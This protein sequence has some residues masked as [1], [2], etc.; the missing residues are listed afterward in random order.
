MSILKETQSTYVR[1]L[2]E[3]ISSQQEWVKFLDFASQLTI[4]EKQYE[5]GFAT[6]IGIY[7]VNPN[8]TYCLL[9][10][11]WNDKEH[12]R[13]TKRKTKG[14]KVLS[15]SRGKT[16]YVNL[17]DV[18]QTGVKNINDIKP[19]QNYNIDI[20]IDVGVLQAELSRRFNIKADTIENQITGIIK[21]KLDSHGLPSNM[22]EFLEQ[23]MKYQIFKRYGFEYNENEFSWAFLNDKPNVYD[24]ATLGKIMNGILFPMESIIEN[25][26]QNE[27]SNIY[28]N[29]NGKNKVGNDRRETSVLGR[30]GNE[31]LSEVQTE[32]GREVVE[33][34][35]TSGRD[36]VLHNN[37][38]PTRERG[39]YR[40]DGG[41]SKG[42]VSDN[43]GTEKTQ[44]VPS[45]ELDGVESQKDGLRTKL[46]GTGD[47][48]SRAIGGIQDSLR[49]SEE[50]R[51]NTGERIDGNEESKGQV[52]INE[53][54]V[55]DELQTELLSGVSGIRETERAY[56]RSTTEDI[57]IDKQ[58][59]D[60]MVEIGQGISE[61][62]GRERLHETSESEE[63]LTE[64]SRG[65][66]STDDSL[67]LN[68]EMMAVENNN[69]TVISDL[70]EEKIKEDLYVGAIV[71]LDGNLWEVTGMSSMMISFENLDKESMT[72]GHSF[73]GDYKVL[74]YKLIKDYQATKVENEN[75]PHI[76]QSEQKSTI[77]ENLKGNEIYTSAQLSL[78]EDIYSAEDKIDEPQADEI[79]DKQE[80]I[81][82]IIR[83]DHSARW[84]DSEKKVNDIQLSDKFSYKDREYTVVS[85]KGIYP[86]DIGIAYDEE[87]SNG[88][89]YQVTENI[90]KYKLI[91]EG[92]YL[93]KE[94]ENVPHIAQ[95]KRYNFRI[96]DME[97]G[98][99]GAK[100]KY[101]NN[102]NAI[103]LLKSL[104]SEGR[105]A[106]PEEQEILS[107]YVGW[108]GLAQAFDENNSQWSNE[109]KELQ[110]LL[111]IEEYESAR[112][113]TLNAHYTSPTVINAMYK[114]IDN[115][116]F[117]TGNI[118]EPS[119]GIGNFLG[120]L[121]ESMSQS[122]LYGVELDSIT[123]RIAKQL[124]QKADISV[125][126]FE[127]KHYP[128]N[129]F[130][131]AIGNVPFGSYKVS[132]KRYDKN[133]WYI[134]DYFI[135]KSLDKVKPNGIIAFITSKGTMDKK[136][137]TVRKYIA[138]RAEL[139]GAIR[140]PNNAFKANAGTEVTS[141][142]LFFQKRERALDIE[143]E[144]VHLSTTE[145]G[146]PIN[147]YFTENPEMVLGKMVSGM[148]MYGNA[149][150]TSCEP[151]ENANLAEQ[152]EK[153]ILNI[154]PVA[155]I[156]SS[157]RKENK[158]EI[159]E[160]I[161]ADMNVK[162]Y[163]YAIIDEKLYFRENSE[164]ELCENIKE[165]DRIKGMVEIRDSVRTL[166]DY[167]IN[168]FDDLLIKSEQKNL[169]QLY[170]VFV[171]KYGII[172]SPENRKAFE[173]DNSFNLLSSLEE[174]KKDEP[175]RKAPIFYK[176][177]INARK[178]I[179]HVDTSAE[180]LVVSLAEKGCVDLEYMSKLTNLSEEKIKEDLIGVIFPN[181][182]KF[183]NNDKVVYETAD[184]YLSGNIREKLSLAKEIAEINPIY[185][186]NVI[187]LEQAMPKPLNAT[188]IDVRLGST[189]IEPKFVEQFIYE[190]LDT[191]YYYKNITGT[192]KNS[193]EVYFSKFTAEWR[194]TNKSLDKTNIKATSTYGTKYK[195]AYQLIE[196]CLN[197]RDTKVW[198]KEIDENGKEIRVLNK[199]A[200]TIVQ[201]KQKEIKQKF[202]D[203]IFKDA[204]RRNY[205]VNKYNILFNST[206]AREY[207]G[208]HI[209]FVGINREIELRPHQKNAIAHA[210][211]GK[212]TL[213][214][215]EVGAGKTFEI[216]ATAM[217]GKR[218]GLHNKS[219]I[220]VPNHLTEQMGDDFIELYPNANILVATKKDFEKNN[221]QKLFA[222]IATGDY[223]A[224]IIG[225]SQIEKIPISVE[226][227]ERLMKE[228]INEI[229]AGIKDLKESNA[230]R[231][232]VKQMEKLKKS[233]EV[234]LTKLLDTP[235]D[236]IVTF[237]ELGIDKLFVDEAH[238]YKNLFLQTKM[239]NVSG[240][241]TNA[242][243]KKTQDLYMKCRYL[244]EITGGKGI[245]F[246]T[247]T[248]VSNSMTE[249]YSMMKYLQAD[250]LE[251]LNMK[252]F[253]AWASNFGETVTAIELAPEGTGYRAKTRFAK[254]FN[255]PELMTIFKECADIKT[256][257]TLDLDIPECE[258]HNI[259]VKPTE[260]QVELVQS[261]SERA[262]KI[263]NRMVDP[264]IDNMLK[265]TTDGRK[266]GLDQRL[267]NPLLPDE[268]GTKVN[269]CVNN[270][271]KI[272]EETKEDRLTQLIFCDFSTPK[273]D[274]SFNLYDDIKNKLIAQGVP[275]EEIAFIHDAKNERQR[276]ILFD[277]VRSGEIRVFIGST[278]KM[279]A[280]TNIQ[281][282]II[283]S[284]DLD[285][286]WKP[287]D[288]TQRLG[289][290][291]RQ[292]NN[293]KKVQL[294]RYVT[295]STFDAYLFQT[296]ENKQRFISQIM[297]S[298][299]PMRSCED[300]DEQTLSFAEIKALCAGN[301][302]IKE[303][304]DLDIDVARLKVL[305]SNYQNNLYTLE[306][307]VLRHLPNRIDKTKKIIDN[308]EK[309][310][311]HLKK[312]PTVLDKDGKQNFSMTINN[313][314]YTDKEKAGLALFESCKKSVIGNTNGK[315]TSIGEFK[316]FK[317][318]ASFDSFSKQFKVYLNNNGSYS[319]VLG[320]SASGNIQRM[321][322][323]LDNL[324][325]KIEDNKIILS[326]TESKLKN[327]IEE[328]KKP[329]PQEQELKTKTARLEELTVLL[330]IDSKKS[331]NVKEE[332]QFD[333]PKY[334]L[335]TQDELE[336][337]EQ[338]DIKFNLRPDTEN[339]GKFIMQHDENDLERIE[340]LLD[341]YE[342]NLTR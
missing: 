106:T 306:D 242:N 113:S 8:A 39:I 63:Q 7:A 258:M 42:N 211:Y 264:S 186:Q 199:N 232:Q 87:L 1:K 3:V 273:A 284:H 26:I 50:S 135:G 138:Q 187:A 310:I 134:H 281:D 64:I 248:P 75:V 22:Y 296:L 88:V 245:V 342:N 30:R 136:N 200:T 313:T 115:M 102:V 58:A 230:E 47:D 290:M 178:I 212:N 11:E 244:D 124:Y 32:R 51:G 161:P 226:R 309:D 55:S 97:L 65:N 188:E 31:T 338:S 227:Q 298:K 27:R 237:E 144:W 329:F 83:A 70:T 251:K 17:F 202:K 269:V 203:W 162:N 174:I 29:E 157:D 123:G 340:E 143:P 151:F 147:Q 184:E 146:I 152:L 90:D 79:I 34:G 325:S 85:L 56:I 18:S 260:T 148:S 303:K 13:Y 320:D 207:D 291:L 2:K 180:S 198:D 327:S 107:K 36:T 334:K 208:S 319:F 100:V 267:I 293:N 256:T 228:Q 219:L 140:L 238:L 210:L 220:A 312:F 120:M 265:V 314:L 170:D 12:D 307:D 86:N 139:I 189:W 300:V 41:T 78:F 43:I 118:L 205:L 165:K 112:A 137:P 163:S 72:A 142:I 279:G 176:R 206:K 261:L 214:A 24:V 10:R 40:E 71:E 183:D 337:M 311:E 108:G 235:K 292:G 223:D 155:N 276:E 241:S 150:E 318:H 53:E 194:I 277:K 246:A 333:N 130:D 129:F 243:V 294:F 213:F 153:A 175:I 76:A 35:T 262:T 302:L 57:P 204:E 166:M 233:L 240:I 38:Q 6:Q 335:I 54:I 330:D 308:L 247:G 301:P 9:Y 221:R 91:N 48:T 275:K 105:L 16:S 252:H 25:T 62:S 192:D 52:F 257:D 197:F 191:P 45:S 82:D 218:L 272:W 297:T 326:E 168:G 289:R 67:R 234:R 28:G 132:D 95:S 49:E 111:S 215:H 60:E 84:G 322:N 110:E 94:K 131:V 268:D 304:M 217:E 271:Y 19:L 103:N 128:D 127:K 116:G 299:A 295:E 37:Q 98:I 68:E 77:V 285:C 66:N 145:D 33:D 254:F 158:E 179:E 305:K 125:T 321:I 104:E 239:Q 101:Q 339:E 274:G 288:M 73:I 280:G 266:I 259:S 173:R 46:G 81:N 331:A 201:E 317:L 171:K 59:N 44:G 23:S 177:T 224:V 229:V 80:D 61:S 253:D 332:F 69:S 160:T 278:S 182:E 4:T 270:V 185:K 169:N 5:F 164:M 89:K 121:P 255:L 15:R 286:P 209:N 316:G 231:F 149:E 323:A 109:Y 14:I 126:G 156:F 263:H 122:K 222:K 216:I 96:T 74:D 328:L 225:H 195:N 282:K 341:G 93:N 196:D 154:K 167:Q 283:A 21:S 287:A 236:D 119:M 190:L 99:G 92:I 249:I 117:K 181:P 250:T 141:D 172:N 324:P 114:A 193:I 315:E 159:I 336:Q 133:N 20:D